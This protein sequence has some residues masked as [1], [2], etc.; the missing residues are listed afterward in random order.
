MLSDICLYGVEKCMCKKYVSHALQ[1]DMILSVIKA[2]L[3]ANWILYCNR[4]KIHTTKTK[5]NS[6]NNKKRKI[7]SFGQEFRLCFCNSIYCVFI[8]FFPRT[9]IFVSCFIRLFCVFFF[10]I[11]CFV[12]QIMENE[13]TGSLRFSVRIFAIKSFYENRGLAPQLL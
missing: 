7:L 2:N 4:K 5:N 13:R 11:F 9:V 8:Y 6:S 12:A 1:N 10:Y 3:K